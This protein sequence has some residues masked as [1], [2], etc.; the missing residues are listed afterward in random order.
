[1]LLVVLAFSSAGLEKM[2]QDD[3]EVVVL[4]ALEKKIHDDDELSLSLSWS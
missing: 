3:D 4:K 1:M 2:N